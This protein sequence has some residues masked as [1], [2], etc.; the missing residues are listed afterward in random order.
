[1]RVAPPLTARA[2]EVR[3]ALSNLQWPHIYP[4]PEVRL[5]RAALAA[6]CGVPAEHLIA[7][8]FL[9]APPEHCLAPP[10]TRAQ[11]LARTR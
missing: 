2:A 10:L 3:E 8:M 1:M 7:G 5:L 9:L 6:E 4:D 11:A